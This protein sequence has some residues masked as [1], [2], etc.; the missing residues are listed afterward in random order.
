M[1][2]LVKWSINLEP[3]LLPRLPHDAP[4]AIRVLPRVGHMPRAVKDL[5]ADAEPLGHGVVGVAL[6]AR[7]RR[8]AV[9]GAVDVDA[10]GLADKRRVVV[11]ARC[12]VAD[13]VRYP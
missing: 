11:R 12:Q 2:L 8:N 10:A 3:C 7:C 6:D 1:G 4:V 13:M 5:L 9:S